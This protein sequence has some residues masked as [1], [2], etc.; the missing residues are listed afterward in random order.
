M[1]V[2]VLSFLVLWRSS[3]NVRFSV[4]GGVET[5]IFYYLPG[6]FNEKETFSTSL[7]SSFYFQ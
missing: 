7:I 1:F 4:W 5:R 6:T 3:V 2:Y